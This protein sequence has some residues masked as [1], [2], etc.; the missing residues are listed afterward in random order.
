VG[1]TKGRQRPYMT[2]TTRSGLLQD[3]FEDTKRNNQNM[4]IE[5]GQTRQWSN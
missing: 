1:L 2:K 5:E 4:L 3:A